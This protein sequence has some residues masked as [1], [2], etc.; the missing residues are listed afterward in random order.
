MLPHFPQLKLPSESQHPA[1][2]PQR[3]PIARLYLLTECTA[4]AP[5]REEQISPSVA[6]LSV[7][8]HAVASR[9]F[10]ERLMAG[11]LHSSTALVEDA[12]GRHL[13]YPKRPDS[14]ADVARLVGTP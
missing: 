8:G 5:V 2:A 4:D 11:L 9:L 12:H 10:P 14:I 6:A 13:L 1:D 7:C 3:Y